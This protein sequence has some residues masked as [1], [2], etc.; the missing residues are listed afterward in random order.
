MIQTLSQLQKSTTIQSTLQT[1]KKSNRITFLTHFRPDADGISSCAALST[2]CQKMGKIVETVYPSESKGVLYAHPEN[3]FINEHKQKPDLL[4]ACD[5]ANYDRLYYPNSFK[6]IPLINIDHHVS[7]L[8]NGTHN[9]VV[10][11]IASTCEL[12][13]SLLKIWDPEVIDEK[14]A[15]MLL[16]GILYDS[17]SFQTSNTNKQTLLIAT[18]LMEHGASLFDLNR[19]LYAQKTTQS[20]QLWGKLLQNIQQSES[21]QSVWLA[22]KKEEDKKGSAGTIHNFIIQNMPVDIVALFS[23]INDTE[24]K[25]SI[26]ST[27]TDVNLLAQKFGGGGHKN[28]AGALVKKSLQETVA[29]VTKYFI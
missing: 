7:N 5:T 28:A 15:S 26:R 29:A 22:I 16:F 11:D 6:E 14:I 17:Q 19:L 20:L 25:I 18:Y 2:W 12:V 10:S 1:I 8:I 4:I 3:V 23:E 13:Y 27:K 21:G 9:L 24:T